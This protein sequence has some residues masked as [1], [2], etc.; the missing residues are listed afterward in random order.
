V[1]ARASRRCN[2]F[3]LIEILV[4]VV[5]VGIVSAIV[6]L[7][8]GLVG[9]D[10]ELQQDSR[11]LAS[12]I[13]LAA[14]E[15]V[16][17][18]R[19]FGLEFMESGYRFVEYDPYLDEWHEIAGDELLRPRKLSQD[20][21]F[22]LFVEER[23]VLLKKDPAKINTG[24]SDDRKNNSPRYAPHALLLSSGEVSPLHV[25]ILQS[26]DKSK[27]SLDLAASGVVEIDASDDRR[28]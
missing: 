11:R 13:D 12:L 22:D 4:V 8:F 1:Q 2:A 15:A 20:L 9:D 5:I 26:S 27:M 18:G 10:R 21:R 19:D 28:Q 6:L 25:D 23:R 16:L 3:T 17:Q 7:S 14:D 24:D